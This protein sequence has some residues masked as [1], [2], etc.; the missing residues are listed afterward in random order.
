L[1]DAEKNFRWAI[2]RKWNGVQKVQLNMFCPNCQPKRI[3][4]KRSRGRPPNNCEACGKRHCRICQKWKEQEKFY[5]NEKG[6]HYR[7]VECVDCKKKLAMQRFVALKGK[8]LE[9]YKSNQT[10]SII[11]R[12]I[13]RSPDDEVTIKT[14]SVYL[15]LSIEELLKQLAANK[16]RL[17]TKSVLRFERIHKRKNSRAKRAL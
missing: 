11:K 13:K 5:T 2:E 9:I 1:Y 8:K 6:T 16:L 7:S 15:G 3:A 10:S 17:S 14:A 4:I 12:R